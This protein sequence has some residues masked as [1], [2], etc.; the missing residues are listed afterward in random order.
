MNQT[1]I[2]DGSPFFN[3]WPSNLKAK[4]DLETGLSDL[5]NRSPDLKS[6]LPDLEARLQRAQ[7]T[8]DF[9][10]ML[11]EINNLIKLY[12]KEKSYLTS[13]RQKVYDRKRKIIFSTTDTK[14]DNRPKLVPRQ[15][16]DVLVFDSLIGVVFFFI[17]SCV[18]TYFSWTQ[19]VILYGSLRFEDPEFY[20]LIATCCLIGFPLIYAI[21]KSKIA[22]LFCYLLLPSYEV[23]T[24][25]CGTASNE[26]MIKEERI[27]KN[28][29]VIFLKKSLDEFDQ[30]YQTIKGQ[31]ENPS[32]KI[33]HNGWYRVNYLEPALKE[34]S[35]AHEK[36]VSKTKELE[37]S[38]NSFDH[39]FYLKI[40]FRIIMYS[41]LMLFVHYL[42]IFSLKLMNSRKTI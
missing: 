9:N 17:F 15:K 3:S 31:Y 6:D 33:F 13:V 2:S 8:S 38:F 7:K 22:F 34:Y 24:V 41:L 19:S 37:S 20:S 21:A 18:L 30:K 28:Y 1:L 12:P 10:L 5:E 35:A 23:Y 27:S 4:S 40:F 16:N 26:V 14:E 39:V 11:S 36:F 29:E 32:S 25:C 42:F